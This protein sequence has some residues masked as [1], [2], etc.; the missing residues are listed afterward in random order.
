MRSDTYLSA[1][2]TFNRNAI[3]QVRCLRKYFVQGATIWQYRLTSSL[4]HH[5]YCCSF[6]RG[7]FLKNVLM[8]AKT[9]IAVKTSDINSVY[10]F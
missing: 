5:L 8:M 6:Y 9:E 7:V 3:K 1:I 2:V 10:L 4:R